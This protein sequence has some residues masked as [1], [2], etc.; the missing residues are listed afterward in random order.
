[1]V[2]AP[3]L[4]M[5]EPATTQGPAGLGAALTRSD[6]C[7]FCSVFEVP[8][9]AVTIALLVQ[10]M[11]S[12]AAMSVKLPQRISLTQTAV[13]LLGNALRVLVIGSKYFAGMS[14]TLSL[15]APPT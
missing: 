9:T 15:C 8:V 7:S 6:L 13:G 1:M 4:P 5:P 3:P 12:G 14:L 2:M 10:L 11:S